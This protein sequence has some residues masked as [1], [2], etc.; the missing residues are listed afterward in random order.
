MEKTQ[1]V[2]LGTGTPNPDPERSGPSLAVVVNDKPY[3]V[4]FGPG[5][6]RRAAAAYVNGVKA[7]QVK[8]MEVT[9]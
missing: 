8:N 9:L 7:L 6:V 4:D 3:I 2:L 1:V 5:G